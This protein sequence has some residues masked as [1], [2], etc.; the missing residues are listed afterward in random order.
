MATTVIN[1]QKVADFS[2]WK[3]GF[4]AGASMRAQAGIHIKGIFQSA[5]DKNSVTVISEVPSV[6][7]AKAIFSSAAMKEAME[8]SGAISAPEIHILTPVQ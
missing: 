6:E 4:E 8:K 7:V 1:T 3:Q 2:K 5:E